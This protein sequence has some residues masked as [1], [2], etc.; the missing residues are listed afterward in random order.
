MPVFISKPDSFL[1]AQKSESVLFR[2][3]NEIFVL[4]LNI[5]VLRTKT[6][7]KEDNFV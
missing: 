1:D 4:G 7:S 2:K 3:K 5:F 6:N